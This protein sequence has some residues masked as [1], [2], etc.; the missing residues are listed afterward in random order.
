MT[1]DL[2]LSRLERCAAEIFGTD[3]RVA[4]SFGGRYTI[5]LNSDVSY[6]DLRRFSVLFNTEALTVWPAAGGLL[7]EVFV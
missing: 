4:P 6:V 3:A 1:E 7:I 5:D 2:V